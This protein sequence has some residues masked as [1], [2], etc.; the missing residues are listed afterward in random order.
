MSLL[1]EDCLELTNL[2]PDSIPLKHY[3]WLLDQNYRKV[4]LEKIL[5]LHRTLRFF[6]SS[7]INVRC[8]IEAMCDLST[9]L[10]AAYLLK[11][12]STNI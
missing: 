6:D 7:Y 2:I 11:N 10:S 9:E 12:A 8:I 1:T 4:D 5:Q 3:S